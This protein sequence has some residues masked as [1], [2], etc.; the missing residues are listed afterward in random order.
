MTIY[1]QQHGTRSRPISSKLEAVLNAAADAAGVDVHVF[2]GGQAAKGTKGARTG[3]TRHDLGNAADLSLTLNGRKLR[4]DNPADLPIIQAFVRAAVKNGATGI[5]AG[6]G[7]MGVGN[8]HVGFNRSELKN[9]GLTL[10]G[11]GETTKTAPAWLKQAASGVQR[12]PPADIPNRPSTADELIASRGGPRAALGYADTDVPGGPPRVLRKGSTDAKTGGAVT[13]LQQQLA[14]AGFDI[15]PHGVDGKFGKDTAAAV[16]EFERSAKLKVERSGVAGPQVQ[17]TLPGVARS[18]NITTAI[19]LTPSGGGTPGGPIV[20][21]LAPQDVVRAGLGNVG[22]VDPFAPGPLAGSPPPMGIGKNDPV[23]SP[24]RIAQNH[25]L[26]MPRPGGAEVTAPLAPDPNAPPLVPPEQAVMTPHSLQSGVA[27]GAP[28]PAPPVVSPAARFVARSNA[29]IARGL[30]HQQ[31]VADRTRRDALESIKDR[32]WPSPALIPEVSKAEQYASDAARRTVPHR[33]QADAVLQRV[34]AARNAPS[35]MVPGGPVAGGLGAQQWSSLQQSDPT[36]GQVDANTRGSPAPPVTMK[37]ETAAGFG[38]NPWS[39]NEADV[40]GYTAGPE[41]LGYTPGQLAD[42]R[43]PVTM[44]QETAA[45]FGVNPWSSNSADVTGYSAEPQGMGAGLSAPSYQPTQSSFGGPVTSLGGYSSRLGTSG[46]RAEDVPGEAVGEL[47]SADTGEVTSPG[48][49]TMPQGWNGGPPVPFGPASP[50]TTPGAIAAG[51]VSG[52]PGGAAGGVPYATDPMRR[53]AGFTNIGNGVVQTPAPRLGLGTR[54]ARTAVPAAA[55]MVPVIGPL[56][57]L[58]ARSAM[59]TGSFDNAQPYRG[60]TGGNYAPAAPNPYGGYTTGSSYSA[61][62]FT[63]SGYTAPSFSPISG[64]P[65]YSY[66][67]NGQGGGTY[68]DSLGR[69][70]PY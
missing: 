68:I 23:V 32:V 15:G 45:G 33:Q 51:N 52:A 19:P 21:S 4:E 69:E 7:Y 34:N 12:L 2:S 46:E 13:R 31:E 42:Y 62:P 10:W 6:A 56:L 47:P 50:E 25:A 3:S 14:D 39:A 61:S 65:L 70:H 55:S 26:T 5:G 18:R 54:I 60:V 35:P 64:G 44:K 1:Q 67:P 66:Q 58:I 16:R 63:P 43:P 22:N 9:A 30:A 11:P 20:P 41:A 49:V 28:I 36:G 37:Q 17:A 29:E 48:V 53:T 38:V 8:L 59:R 57:G 40:S 24:V 27:R